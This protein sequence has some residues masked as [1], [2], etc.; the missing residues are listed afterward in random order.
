M[1]KRW[2]LRQEP[3][4]FKGLAEKLGVSPVVVRCIRNRGPETE[5]EM[6]AYLYA[7]MDELYDPVL[8]PG[9]NEA[10]E[11]LGGAAV[12]SAGA[13]ESGAGAVSAGSGVACSADVQESGAGVGAPRIAIASDYDC[14]GICS[15]M[16]LKNGLEALGFETN[17]YTPDRVREGYGLNRRIV[18]DAVR[19][20]CELLITCDNGIAANDAVSYAKEKGLTVIVTDHHEPQEE[21]PAADVIIDPKADEMVLAAAGAVGAAGSAGVSVGAEAGSAGGSVGT[22]GSAGAS[23]GTA[24]SAGTTAEVSA[25]TT[26]VTSPYPYPGLCGAGVAYKLIEALYDKRG[27]AIGTDLLELAAIATITDV[28]ELTGENRIIVKY[29][30]QALRRTENKGL[31][32]LL[33][34]LNLED[35]PIKASDIAFRIGPTLNATGRIADVEDAFLLLS[36]TDDTKAKRLAEKLVGLNDERKQMMEDGTQTALDLL[37]QDFPDAD[38][39]VMDDVLVVYVPDVHESIVGL[40]AGRIK[41]R[42][43]HPAI[44]FTD[45]LCDA[46]TGEKKLKGSGRSIKGYHMFDRLMEVK[47]LTTAFGGHEMAAGL[48]IPEAN[49]DTLRE[50]LN[51]NSGLN[52]DDFV[53]ELAIDLE[54]PLSYLSERLIDEIDKMGPFGVA[55]PRPVFAVR[56]LHVDRVQYM[57]KEKQHLKLY[58]KEDSGTVLEAVAFFRAA[59]FDDEIIA[60]Y[61]SDELDAIR[62]GRSDKLLTL[63]YQPEINEFNGFRQVQLKIV[64]WYL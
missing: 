45:G 10:V 20:G 48:T 12:G 30:L 42:F 11:L 29:G 1:K 9:V 32:N 41:E 49:L 58:V 26:S 43:N 64:E 21:L 54:V 17:I 35:V 47:D 33:K 34:L 18:D 31:R 51:A 13:Q 7:G 23:V 3:A 19:D 62:H 4:D 50:K 53:P 2:V 44:C 8:M 37:Y 5:D 27:L 16:I 60:K 40:I 6:R 52:E 57:G 56:N 63:A 59:E 14:D 38:K 55:N 24:G 46:S 15:G 39:G 61:N 25:G 22:A 28:M 36:E